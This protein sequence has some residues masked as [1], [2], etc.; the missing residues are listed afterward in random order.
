MNQ[1]EERGRV[2]NRHKL[3]FFLLAV[4]VAGL[5]A[6]PAWGDEP[7]WS[8]EGLALGLDNCSIGCP[9]IFGEPPTHGI[10]NFVAVFQNTKA[11]YG[12]VNLNGV[13]YAMVGEFVRQKPQDAATWRYVAYY[14]DVQAGERQK[15]ALKAIL[16]GPAF[17]PLGKPAELKEVPITLTGLE[18]FG[19]VGKTYGGKVGNIA[20]VQ[21]TPIQGAIAGKPVV[22]ENSL[23][24]LWHWTCLG[25]ATGSFY[26][27]GGQNFRF[28]GTSGESHKF[29]FK[30]GGRLGSATSRIAL[31]CS[32]QN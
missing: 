16:T 19:Q 4:I 22:I 7:S 20:E 29:A 6:G 1:A 26:S 24:P 9:C 17:A 10:C 13:K 8:M 32:I 28:E 2:M 11:N 14:I 31:C 15:R 30:G 27:A 3:G 12:D 21:V 5:G 18:S 25:K 23:E